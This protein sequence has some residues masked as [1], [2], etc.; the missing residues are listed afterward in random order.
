MKGIKGYIQDNHSPSKIITTT[1][2]A[3]TNYIAKTPLKQA[4]H[5]LGVAPSSVSGGQDSKGRKRYNN[6]TSSLI[7]HSP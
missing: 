6:L 3:Y 1:T 4:L 5:S 7:S 2:N